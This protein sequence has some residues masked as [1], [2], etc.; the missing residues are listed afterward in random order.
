MEAN[1][2]LTML[3]PEVVLE[4]LTFFEKPFGDGVVDMTFD[5]IGQMMRWVIE[6]APIFLIVATGGAV[7]ALLFPLIL[8]IDHQLI[9]YKGRRHNFQ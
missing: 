7:P 9:Y 1:S 4:V 5:F 3:V 2:T 6:P 8:V